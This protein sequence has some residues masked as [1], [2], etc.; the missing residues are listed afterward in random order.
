MRLH[1]DLIFT[2]LFAVFA[3][4]LHSSTLFTS[5]AIPA[6]VRFALREALLFGA[7]GVGFVNHYLLPQLRSEMP[8]LFLAGPLLSTRERPLFEVT[9]MHVFLLVHVQYSYSYV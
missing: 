9:R 3:F 8:F 1:N 7:I 6:L 4:A 5:T 2:V